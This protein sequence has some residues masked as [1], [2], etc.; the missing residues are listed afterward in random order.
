MGTKGLHICLLPRDSRASRSSPGPTLS[1]PL[2][3]PRNAP[4]R[5]GSPELASPT[6][7][8]DVL[9]LLLGHFLEASLDLSRKRDMM[10]GR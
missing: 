4:W 9:L 1:S 8:D 3:L 5:V 6:N 2:D 7:L 10:H